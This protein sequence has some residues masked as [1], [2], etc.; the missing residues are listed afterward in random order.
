MAL[1]AIL[2]LESKANPSR[3]NRQIKSFCQ[4]KNAYKR[5]KKKGV[6]G[7]SK[8]KTACRW[9]KLSTQKLMIS[10]IKT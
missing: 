5:K 3:V 10:I 9:G 6:L 7:I 4:K 2:H 8:K 1:L